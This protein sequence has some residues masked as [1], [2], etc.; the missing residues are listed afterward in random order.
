MINLNKYLASSG[1]CSRRQ[2]DIL[3]KSGSV[4]I[5]D[6]IAKPIDRVNVGD[7]V[8]V[9]DKLI[10]LAKKKIYLAFNKPRGVICTTDKNS[11]NTI[12]DYI[13]IPERVFPIGRLDVKSE[14]LIL[15]TNDGDFANKILKTKQVEKEYI[16]KVDKN[17]NDNFL[18]KLQS[19]IFLDG[20]KTLSTNVTT[21]NQV[22]FKIILVEGRKR[23]I[24]RMCDNLHYNVIKLKRIRIGKILLDDI[25]EGKFIAINPESV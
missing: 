23:Q 14:G 10:T 11:H 18:S 1:L 21:V 9:N 15:L 13:K 3:I 24:R 6:L 12:M 5:N 7:K 2:A 4:K 25:P 8:F 19:G 16:V 17:L 22:T 20:R